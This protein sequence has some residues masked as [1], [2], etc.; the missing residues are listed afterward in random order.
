METFLIVVTSLAVWIF[1]VFGMAVGW[2][3]KFG[4]I[5]L[6]DMLFFCFMG[7]ILPAGFLIAVKELLCIKFNTERQI[8]PRP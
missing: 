2:M 5:T 4:R 1:N 7:L 3:R 8:W 6:G